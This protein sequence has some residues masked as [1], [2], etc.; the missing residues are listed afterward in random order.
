MAM[1][2]SGMM[3]TTSTPV[4]EPAKPTVVVASSSQAA[5]DNASTTPKESNAPKQLTN[6]N[7]AV[8]ST[9]REYFKDVPI[10]AEVA[11]CESHFRQFE[12]DGTIFRGK[13]TTK[14]VGVMQVNEY[15]HLKR[16]QK[17]GYNIHTIEGNLAYARLLYKE[18][19]TGPW[20]SSSPCWMKSDVAKAMFGKNLVAVK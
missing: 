7:R 11:K 3:S 13:I 18:E 17:L 9:V 19:G 1:I 15:Y 5:A 10:M 12:K 16:A 4:D 20:V 14:D 6:P 2:V 8:E